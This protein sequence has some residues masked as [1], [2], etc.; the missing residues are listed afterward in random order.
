[1]NAGEAG[2]LATTRSVRD[3]HYMRI[4]L[5]RPGWSGADL[6]Y[7]GDKDPKFYDELIARA[8]DGSPGQIITGVHTV[9][10]TRN[11]PSTSAPDPTRDG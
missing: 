10:P 9:V 2:R 1:M 4:Y 6:L 8:K 3:D 5:W 11:R 7:L